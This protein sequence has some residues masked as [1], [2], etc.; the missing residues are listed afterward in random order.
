MGGVSHHVIRLLDH[1]QL[2]YLALFGDKLNGQKEHTMAR[3]ELKPREAAQ[4]PLAALRRGVVRDT[5]E[6]DEAENA[7]LY[8]VRGFFG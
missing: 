4:R 6:Q 8:P 5:E 3:A 2:R 1:D 7:K